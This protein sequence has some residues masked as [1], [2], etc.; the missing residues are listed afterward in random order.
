MGSL[1]SQFY[2]SNLSITLW[3]TCLFGLVVCFL[4]V[5]S[6]IYWAISV[7]RFSSSYWYK[8]NES[9]NQWINQTINQSK[10][11]PDIWFILT[12]IEIYEVLRQ[13][14]YVMHHFS[15]LFAAN[16]YSIY[17]WICVCVY[18]LLKQIQDFV[19]RVG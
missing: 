5:K 4:Q 7:N 6:K 8:W 12:Y 16:F 19:K 18:V 3:R 10:I 2:F 15:G 11:N 9:M 14:Y 13:N 17:V 1:I